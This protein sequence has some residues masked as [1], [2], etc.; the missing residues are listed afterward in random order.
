MRIINRVNIIVRATALLPHMAGIKIISNPLNTK[1]IPPTLWVLRQ[2][3]SEERVQG[4]RI[5]I[6]K[7]DGI[8][9][10]TFPSKMNIKPRA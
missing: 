4:V 10:R 5:P 2:T 7:L 6:K 8:F 9:G 1:H 3:Y